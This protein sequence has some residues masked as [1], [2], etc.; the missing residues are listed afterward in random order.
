MQLHIDVVLKQSTTSREID[1]KLVQTNSN[2]F[3]HLEIHRIKFPCLLIVPTP[4]PQSRNA[5]GPI[6]PFVVTGS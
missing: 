3:H 2:V 1:I 4:T 5:P 6:Q